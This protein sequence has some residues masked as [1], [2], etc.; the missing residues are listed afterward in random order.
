MVEVRTQRRDIKRLWCRFWHVHMFK[1]LTA[2]TC[3]NVRREETKKTS[4]DWFL[5]HFRKRPKEAAE[6]V[7]GKH[8]MTSYRL[9]T[10]KLL[11]K[12]EVPDVDRSLLWKHKNK[13][14]NKNKLPTSQNK[15]NYFTMATVAIAAGKKHLFWGGGDLYCK[16][17]Q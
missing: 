13:N 14:K 11:S 2:N 6:S 12:A 10:S 17:T 15:P 3:E 4:T 8:P 9:K 5:K 16:T 7:Q 1:K